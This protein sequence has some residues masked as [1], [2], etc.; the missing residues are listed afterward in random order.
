[1]TKQIRDIRE[2]QT[3]LAEAKEG[4][5]FHGGEKALESRVRLMDEEL[6]EFKEALENKDIVES[7]KEG[8]DLLYVIFGTFQE[9]GIL[10]EVEYAWDLVHANN[11]TKVGLDGVVQRD[12]HGKVIKPP[13]F[14]KLD[15]RKTF[16]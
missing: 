9:A 14:K 1:M 8:V 11:M 16:L 6:A 4:S 15:L 3:K 10:E 13:H 2:F 7:I 5:L 12:E